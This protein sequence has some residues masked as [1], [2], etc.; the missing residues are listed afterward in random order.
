MRLGIWVLV[1]VMSICAAP[2]IKASTV[3]FSVIM[4]G[5]Q[6]VPPTGSPGTGTATVMI[7]DVADTVW[8][9]L[10]Y[11]GL[12]APVT[13]AHIHCCVGPAGN[14]SPVIPFVPA[15]FVLGGTSGTFMHTFTGVAPDIIAGLEA[16]MGYI[17]I[18]SSEFPNGEI[19][20]NLTPEPGTVAL[21][22]LG[23]AAIAF[24]RRRKIV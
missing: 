4:S 6:D 19:R 16:G 12:V 20:G 2:Q 3:T 8:V 14:A 11:S 22:G 5:A 10:S 15:G 1:A 24:V 13:N 18:H 21:L 9:D 17:N 7:D 23:L